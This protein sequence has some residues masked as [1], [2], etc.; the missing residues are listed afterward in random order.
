M[1][2]NTVVNAIRYKLITYKDTHS[3]D[4]PVLQTFIYI[5][6]E[7]IYATIND[8]KVYAHIAD[9]NHLDYL[10]NSGFN[11]EKDFEKITI[12]HEL[13]TKLKKLAIKM[14]KIK[15]QQCDLFQPF[16]QL[17]NL[18]IYEILQDDPNDVSMDDDIFTLD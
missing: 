6:S 11:D 13:V 5:E 12:D 18:P 8:N 1:Q 14:Q 10:H 3:R 17:C 7:N 2:V 9:I 15:Q 16:S 4:N